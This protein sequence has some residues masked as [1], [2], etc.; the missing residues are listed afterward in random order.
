MLTDRDVT[1]QMQEKGDKM[2]K[3]GIAFRELEGKVSVGRANSI[4]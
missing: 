1:R 3:I 2:A 4:T